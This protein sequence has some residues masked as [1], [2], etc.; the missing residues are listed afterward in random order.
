MWVPGPFWGLTYL[1]PRPTYPLEEW[2]KQQQ[3]KKTKFPQKGPGTQRVKKH[4]IASLTEKHR[5]IGLSSKLLSNR[6]KKTRPNFIWQHAD[7]FIQSHHGI[8]NA[9][10]PSR[11]Y[12]SAVIRSFI[13][14][15]SKTWLLIGIDSI[16][17]TRWHK[18]VPRHLAG[19]SFD[20]SPHFR[21]LLM[22][23]YR[24]HS[25]LNTVE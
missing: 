14:H 23:T 12:Q 10:C 7:S 15:V 19:C 21:P 22:A 4:I 18:I 24:V 6:I 11:L 8:A 13:C 1:P 5:L 17:A 2:R 9:A 16:V 20:C 25:W 3:P